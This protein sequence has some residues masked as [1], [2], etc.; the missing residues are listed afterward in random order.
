VDRVQDRVHDQPSRLAI[1]LSSPYVIV[2]GYID[3]AYYKGGVS[4]LDEVSLSADLDPVLGEHTPLWNYYWWGYGMGESRAALDQKLVRG[5]P[6]P[7]HEIRAVY[8][9]SADKSSAGPAAFPL[10]YG[11]QSG[12]DR[13]RLVA[14]LQ[15]NPDS[16]PALSLGN[17]TIHYTDDTAEPHAL[18]ITYK[19]RE[20]F[21]RRAPVAPAA[22]VPSNGALVDT[23]APRLEWAA[24]HG[25]GNDSA[26]NY[27]VQVSQR[28]DCAWPVASALDRDVREGTAFQ[29]PGGWLNPGATYYWRVRAEDALGS[30]GPWSS[31]VRFTTR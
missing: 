19:W 18:R 17:N 1:T 7:T 20:H 25:A 26:V 2:G 11:G 30:I 29:T 4:K 9:I 21:D 10:V 8:S 3:T 28:P 12:L 23:L 6:I 13:V 24:P 14:D 5:G 31:I 15:V 27:R 16:L 22:M